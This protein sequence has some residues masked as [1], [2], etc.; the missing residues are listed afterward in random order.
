MKTA[1]RIVFSSLTVLLATLAVCGHA[2]AQS[3]D[4]TDFPGA[5]PRVAGQRSAATD[6]VL[7]GA[8]LTP[9]QADQLRVSR[10]LDLSSLD[11]AASDIWS[12]SLK[13]TTI[14]PLNLNPSGDTFQYLDTVKSVIGN[15]RFT[16]QKTD[17]SGVPHTYTIFFSKNVHNVLLRRALLM[18]MG[19]NVPDVKL[20]KKFSVKFSGSFSRNVFITDM[21]KNTFGD[22]GRWIL[23]ANEKDVDTAVLQDAVVISADNQ[24]YDLSQGSVTAEIVQ[25]RRALNSLLVPYN[26]VDVPESVN[27]LTWHPGRIM[28]DMIYLP[29]GDA[30][31]LNPSYDDARW[32]ATLI[33]PL[34]RDD[35]KQ[36]VAAGQYPAPVAALLVEKLVSRRNTM[37]SYFNVAAPKLSFDP[38][39]SQG[40]ALVKGKIVVTD[41]PG[42]GSRFAYGDP[43][44]PLS[45]SE[46]RAFAKS[47]LFGTLIDNAVAQF[48][49]SIV[50][51]TDLNAKVYS[52]EVGLAQ[53]RF[54]N[55][56]KT[57]QDAKTSFGMWTTPMFAGHLIVSRDI[58][59]GSYL[60]T[61]N[62]VQIADSFGFSV[63]GGLFVGLDGLPTALNVS[64]QA[65]LG[66]VR[67]YTHIKP[68]KSIKAAIKEPFKNVV[69]PL[70]KKDFAKT[71]DAVAA[72][73]PSEKATP[74]LQTLISNTL[75]KFSK[76]MGVG[77]SILITDSLSAAAGVTAS[78]GIQKNIDAYAAFSASK[79]IIR[80][81][82]IYRKDDNTIQLYRDPADYSILSAS[83]G[84]DAFIPIFTLKLQR[85][86]G[87]SQTNFYSLNIQPDLDKNADVIADVRALR[88]TLLENNTEAADGLQ[89]PFVINHKFE[90]KSSDTTFLLWRWLGLET[91][92]SIQAIAPTGEKKNFL[93]WSEGKMSGKSYED[94]ASNLI[95]KTL[96]E[97]SG[98][99][100][101]V[102][103]TPG[104]SLP[105]RGIYGS[106]VSRS[107]AFESEVALPPSKKVIN[108]SYVEINYEWKGW[109]I[110][111]ADILKIIKEIS[112]KFSFNF[113]PPNVLQTTTK[114][115]LYSLQMKMSVY[116]DGINTLARTPV[117]TLKNILIRENK[118]SVVD[119]C[120]PGSVC[121]MYSHDNTQSN[122]ER[123]M[124]KFS[125]AQKAYAAALAAGNAV[126]ASKQ[127]M[128]M[129]SAVETVASTK[130]LIEMVGG[131]NN[132][133][134]Q[135][136][137]NGFRE[138]D[139][140]GD[141]AILSDTLGQIG[142]AKRNGPLRFV[143]E[144]L[145]MTDSEFFDYW[146]LNKI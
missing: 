59:T 94:L 127:G 16:V 25:G 10:K 140:G 58:V 52:H 107:T 22:A 50:P 65:K 81:L 54:L 17:E 67:T 57:G 56:L 131:K 51:H 40:S 133:F 4:Y 55:Y 134:V 98:S 44:A 70:L 39:I 106:S 85:K 6:L 109:E 27:L 2:N 38:T 99:H 86:A 100:S 36:I 14:S 35:F 118:F 34:T 121:Q 132:I 53:E 129:V 19:Y 33:A 143:Q 141:T 47:R 96:E 69:V 48:N 77:E 110:S 66:F 113:Y 123:A 61:D 139:E 43:L 73:S 63:E 115:Q 11:P 8:I 62:L 45:S 3:T 93:Y 142:S 101:I 116:G 117:Q 12:R 138:N 64:G 104:T 126:E 135:S 105:G 21:S 108:E 97:L 119:D 7:N 124:R 92:D 9:D 91:N 80:R 71:L 13:S 88:S 79:I 146:I 112:T 95:A 29:Y 75:T 68:I 137:I 41:F 42:Y 60:G 74:E 128:M 49:S 122:S 87:T 82:Q 28:N 144:N 111:K 46:I 102:V 78:Y 18:K 83:V 20:L 31:E 1:R 26:L 23:N 5:V 76:Q 15:F 125:S 145:G 37:M 84:F 72:L 30:D 90:E 24:I 32:S 120:P 103:Q 89:K 114:I 136:T 130:G